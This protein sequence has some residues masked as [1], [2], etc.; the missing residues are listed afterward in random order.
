MC[1]WN[2]SSATLPGAARLLPA[3]H[4]GLFEP[5]TTDP[6]SDPT[7][8][9]PAGTRQQTSAKQATGTCAHTAVH[10]HTQPAL[11]PGH[12]HGQGST[13]PPTGVPPRAPELLSTPP[14]SSTWELHQS[15]SRVWISGQE[16]EG[17]AR[18]QEPSWPHLLPTHEHWDRHRSAHPMAPPP[19]ATSH[20][21]LPA[22]APG[23]TQPV[24]HVAGW[25]SQG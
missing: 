7:D 16:K 14:C 12:R 25:Q 2:Q 20:S 4:T 13:N 24:L 19:A 18:G 8:P 21:L 3:A 23:G 10:P 22:T 6:P 1:L 9:H 17:T 15:S 5:P 11:S